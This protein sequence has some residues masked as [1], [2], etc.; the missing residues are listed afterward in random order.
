VQGDEAARVRKGNDVRWI[1]SQRPQKFLGT[2]AIEKGLRSPR[3]HLTAD[4]DVRLIPGQMHHIALMRPVE[5]VV[6]YL[7]GNPLPNARLEWA[8][9]FIAAPL[10]RGEVTHS[11]I[12][13]PNSRTRA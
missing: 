7:E 8:G 12:F 2:L 1:E 6:K 10:D 5:L 11:T 4:E 13:P 3:R 9:V